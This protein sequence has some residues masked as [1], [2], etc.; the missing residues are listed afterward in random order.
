MKIINKHNEF[1]LNINIF[2]NYFFGHEAVLAFYSIVKTKLFSYRDKII[3][4]NDIY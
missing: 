4:T 1:L 3:L 2:V